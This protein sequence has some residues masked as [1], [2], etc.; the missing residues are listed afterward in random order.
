MK[1]LL[2]SA[3]PRRKELIK[4]ISDEVRV[5]PADCDETLPAGI[6][7]RAAVEYLSLLKG[8]AVKDRAFEDETVVSA[9]TVVCLGSTILGKP[10]DEA[11]AAAMLKMLSGKTH[12]V[13]TGVSLIKGEKSA[14]FSVATEVT[15]YELSDREI[16]DYV[17]TGEPA[18]K[19]GAYGI[20]GKGALLV[21]KINGD[22]LNVVG[23]PVAALNKELIKF[24]EN[25]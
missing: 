24:T 19:A 10:A 22:Y 18:D 14:V 20:Q 5:C 13:Y 8:S 7:G 9:D 6:T 12:T 21:E 1:I 23:L 16:A 4:Y 25:N 17:L 3:S 2:A 15:F 11:D